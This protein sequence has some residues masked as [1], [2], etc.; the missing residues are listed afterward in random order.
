ME[1]KD[2]IILEENMEQQNFEQ[3]NR[4]ISPVRARTLP[5]AMSEDLS[6]Y[7]IFFSRKR[8]NSAVRHVEGFVALWDDIFQSIYI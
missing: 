1:R 6:A 8:K 5:Y 4:R 2:F 3:K 7:G